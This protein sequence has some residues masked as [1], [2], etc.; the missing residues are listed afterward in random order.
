MGLSGSM[1]SMVILELCPRVADLVMDSE[2]DRE[3]NWN[4]VCADYEIKHELA[5][6]KYT[7]LFGS[8]MI[9]VK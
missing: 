3:E 2:R 5:T 9:A 6:F 8:L 4:L 7:N 1:S